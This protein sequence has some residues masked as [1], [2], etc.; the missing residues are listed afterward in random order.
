MIR[1][2]ETHSIGDGEIALSFVRSPGPGGQNV[3]KVSTAVELRFD[4]AHSPS[5]PPAVKGRLLELAG[6]RA[7]SDG[8]VI[9]RARRFRTQDENRRDAVA[10]LAD[11]VRRAFEEPVER[12]PTEPTPR[13]RSLR[14]RSKA[15][16]GSTKAARSGFVPEDEWE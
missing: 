9:I 5:I 3:N 15:R 2:D 6:R 7:T 8:V 10:R 1:I 11:L 14:I 4:A 12:I 13:S 16:R